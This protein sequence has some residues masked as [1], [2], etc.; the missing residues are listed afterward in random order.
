V[1]AFFRAHGVIRVDQLETLFEIA[2]LAARYGQSAAAGIAHAR[3]AVITTTG[4][5]AATVVDNLGLYGLRTATPPFTFVTHM[6]LRG[7]KIRETP[8]IDLT[9]AATSAQYKDLL[10]QLL[11]S[12][13]CDAVLSV[14][15][16]SAQFHPGLAVKPLIEAVKPA[17]KPLAVFLSPEAP[18]SL[19]LLQ[20][21]GIA[22]FRTPEACADGLAALFRRRPVTTVDSPASPPTWPDDVPLRGNFTEYEAG[23][24]FTHMGIPVAASAMVKPEDLTHDIPYPVVAKVSSPDILHK[25]EVGGVQVGIANTRQLRVRVP[26]LIRN[27]AQKVPNARIDGVLIQKME[28]S[29]LELMLGYRLDPLVGPTVVL[30]AGGISAELLPDF[31]VRL[32][33]V[34]DTEAR[35]MINEVRHTRLIRGFRGLPPGDC[36]E[37]ARVIAKFSQLANISGPTVLEAE[38]NPLFVQS[39]AV[40]AVDGLIRLV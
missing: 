15:G 20:Q 6:A 16:S 35:E 40:V 24:I 29:L 1:N 5:G 11:A 27:V 32:A 9:L 10:E 39:N 7:L 18:E 13:W 38:I 36:N 12:D 23:R 8:I 3:V 37:L 2:P 33:P 19:R 25:T 30:S 21:H 17:S 22:A 34:T 4:G 31:S 26:E 14:V 28:T